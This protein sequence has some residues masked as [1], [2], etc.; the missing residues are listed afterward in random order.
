MVQWLGGQIAK[1][2][3]GYVTRWLD[4]VVWYLGDKVARSMGWKSSW[5][6]CSTYLY[7]DF[8]L[9][10]RRWLLHTGGSKIFEPL[11]H[12]GMSTFDHFFA[13]NTC[14]LIE[15]ELEAKNWSIEAENMPKKGSFLKSFFKVPAS[16]QEFLKCATTKGLVPFTQLV[17]VR[18]GKLV[19]A[20]SS[21]RLSWNF[22]Q[23][24][25]GTKYE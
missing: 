4:Y 10:S 12:A 11:F 2:A 13:E 3:G 23:I 19:L 24:I 18:R 8:H 5:L 7:L 20:L 25:Y 1:W 9:L 6:P 14:Q 15:E 21:I 17:K 22:Y 16:N